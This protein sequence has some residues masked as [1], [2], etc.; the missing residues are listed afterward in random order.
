[1]NLFFYVF[2]RCCMFCGKT[3]EP[4]DA[5]G[6]CEDCARGISEQR[7]IIPSGENRDSVAVYYFEGPARRGLHRFKYGDKIALGK[8]CGKLL[9]ARFRVRGDRG[10]VVTCV[11][12]AKDGRPR[13][14]NQSAVIAKAMAKELGLP[15]DPNLLFKRKGICPQPEC[16]T[17]LAREENAKRAYRNGPSKRDLSGQS[18]VLVDDLYTTGAT[19]NA[20]CNILKKRGA[21]DTLTYTA[22]RVRAEG[23]TP[24]VANFDRPL[25]HED[26]IDPFSHRKRRFRGIRREYI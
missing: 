10:H 19:V 3:V 11:P 6:I 17:H 13:I 9:A 14:Y 8:F 4:G 25:V 2:G 26:F 1:M 7:L 18:V 21:A 16:P 24:L 22:M 23:A 20:C 15:F 5:Y 12:R